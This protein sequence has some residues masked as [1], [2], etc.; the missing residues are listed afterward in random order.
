MENGVYSRSFILSLHSPYWSST[1]FCP[2]KIRSDH[3]RSAFKIPY[4]SKTA[5]WYQLEINSHYSQAG[6]GRESLYKALSP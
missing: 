5:I 1:E 6:L 4:P 3:Y 2:I